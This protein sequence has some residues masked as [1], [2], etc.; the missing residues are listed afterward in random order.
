MELVLKASL[1][2]I[3]TTINFHA[4]IVFFLSEGI[5]FSIGPALGYAKHGEEEH[6]EGEEEEEEE[7]HSDDW[8]TEFG[9]HVELCAHIGRLEW[10][11]YW[12][13]CY[14]GESDADVC[15]EYGLSI[16]KHF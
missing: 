14:Y 3:L 13:I 12:H 2:V 10:I 15:S 1:I 8:E 5:H 11:Y 6:E 16:G 4:G 7:E 9:Y